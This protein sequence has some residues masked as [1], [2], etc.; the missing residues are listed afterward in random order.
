MSGGNYNNVG[1]TPPYLTI[2]E[3]TLLGWRPDSFEELTEEGQYELGPV[4]GNEA[5]VSLTGND[6]EFFLYEFRQKTGWDANLPNSGLLIYHVDMSE[7]MVGG[8]SALERWRTWN[9]INAYASHQC[10]DLVEAV[11]PESAISFD[12]Q[13][14]FP[15]TKNNT[16]FTDTS[17][18]KAV[19]FA[20]N[21][22]GVYLV[23][24]AD[25]GDRASFTVTKSTEL[26]ITGTVIDPDG[27][28]V[29]GAEVTLSF[30][31]PSPAR[32]VRQTAIVSSGPLFTSPRRIFKTESAV[33]TRAEDGNMYLKPKA[34]RTLP[35]GA[36][37][38]FLIRKRPGRS[39][40]PERLPWFS[41]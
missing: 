32:D 10:C 36:T 12:N 15:G 28:P 1:R 5:Y 16:S 30:E 22:T 19:D 29:P 18:P 13:I 27:N 6:G 34:G 31:E 14:P 4:P 11:Y 41:L 38:R 25:N 17:S 39:S 7:N 26:T 23:N 21:P 20:G 3:R 33:V 9:G 8:I 2:I 35:F 40:A 37:K 24:I